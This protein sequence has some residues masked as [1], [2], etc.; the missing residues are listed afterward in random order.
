M[1]EAFVARLERHA[2]RLSR[3]DD[4]RVVADCVLLHVDPVVLVD[5]L[6][7]HVCGRRAG[8]RSEGHKKAAMSGDACGM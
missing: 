6:P 4:G 7:L 2:G 1:V 8:S 3:E 5:G